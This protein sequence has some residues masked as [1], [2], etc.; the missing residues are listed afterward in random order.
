[1]WPFAASVFEAWLLSQ[2]ASQKF[3]TGMPAQDWKPS[4]SA[5]VLELGA[6]TIMAIWQSKS[7]GLSGG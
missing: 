7:L 4:I 5:L 3:M 6:K 2:V 1:M